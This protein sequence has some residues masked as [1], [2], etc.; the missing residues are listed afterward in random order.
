M[1]FAVKLFTSTHD[2][3]EFSCGKDMLD[4][5]IRHQARQD[6]KKKVAVCF[7]LEGDN[8]KIKGYSTLSNGSIPRS[9]LPEIISKSLPKYED[10]PVTML[11]RLAVDIRFQGM[12][13][14]SDLL[15]DALKRSY[16]TSL[17]S[18][19]SMAVVVDPIDQ[20]ATDFYT[21]YGF[22]LLPDRKRM[23]LPMSTI[24]QLIH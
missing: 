3:A 2:R 6:M 4:N 19:A 24:V 13:I 11:G 21:K 5:Y 7:V 23:F 22:I 14:G 15:F 9:I 16:E 8:K 17:K 10:L 20:E 12:G 1:S 18:I